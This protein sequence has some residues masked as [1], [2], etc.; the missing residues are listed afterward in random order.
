VTQTD[1]VTRAG[2]R[3]ASLLRPLV[4]VFVGALIALV[5]GEF[6]SGVAA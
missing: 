1:A 5:N 3:K 4:A 6:E 2:R